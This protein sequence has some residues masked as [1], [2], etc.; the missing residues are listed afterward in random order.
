MK[1]ITNKY[2]AQILYEIADLLEM[3]NELVFKVRAYQR[4]AREIEEYPEPISDIKD[5]K[6]LM[7]IPG[8]GESIAKKL[9]EIIE[10]G[11]CNYYEQLKKMIPADIVNLIRLEGVGPKTIKTLYDK[12]GIKNVKD[13][14]EATKLHKI[15]KLE[16]F[17]IKSEENIIKS[18]ESFKKRSERFRL[19]EALGYADI[20]IDKMKKDKSTVKI[21]VAGSLRRRKETIGDIDLLMVSR[22]PKSSI[23]IF[24]KLNE[25][26]EVINKGDTKASIEFDNGFQADLLV[27]ESKSFGAA[28]Q[29][30]TGNKD[31][32]VKVRQIAI[33]KGYKL[34]EY[35]LFN[36]KGR[37]IVGKEEKEI[38][39]KLGMEV[40][41]P[42]IRRDDGEI[43][44]AL[45]NKLPHLI[46]EKDILGDLQMHTKFSDGM[47]TVS[48]MAD[49]AKNL[50]YKYIAVTEHNTEGLEVAGGV[51]SKDIP[52]YIKK[53]KALK[54]SVKV[55]AG[56]EVNID[57]DGSLTVPDEYLKQ[58]DIVIIAIH[59][60]FKM[61]KD[62]MT[63]RILKAFENPYV[64]IFAHPTGRLLLGRDG[65][66]FDFEAVC[67]KGK[68]KNI[69]LELNAYPERLDLNGEMA[70]LAKSFGCKFSIGTDAHSIN[71]LRYLKYGVFMA[72]RGWLEKKDV[73]NTYPYDKL[74]QFLEK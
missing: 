58:L 51:K 60:N 70:K 21:E 64:N 36:K 48:E 39:K 5:E 74:V 47:N 50:G 40:P 52:K 27:I 62:E 16:G 73:I 65:Y 38:Y 6:K 9:M 63:K 22:N 10:T 59:S 66:D 42:E 24:S 61:P 56:I 12:L 23:E 26:S 69:C 2:I 32:N 68:E 8:V 67:K 18:I 25:V 4:V 55:L 57:K 17:G 3:E 54:T 19:D 29:Y 20:I 33:K 72:R 46:E 1:K 11:T 41:P 14:E 53:I 15:Q 45:S 49:E 44:A 31:H 7:E 43:E 13:L 34:N 28:L 37:Y 71:Q 35:G 30:F